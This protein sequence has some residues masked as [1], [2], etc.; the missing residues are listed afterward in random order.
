MRKQENAR[1]VESFLHFLIVPASVNILKGAID[2]DFRILLSNKQILSSFN[3]KLNILDI[4]LIR[5]LNQ[6][7]QKL[8]QRIA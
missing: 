5:D 7:F 3:F 6:F 4:N 8:F 2:T 1:M